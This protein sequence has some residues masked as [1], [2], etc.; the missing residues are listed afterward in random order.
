MDSLKRYLLFEFQDEREEK[1]LSP[2]PREWVIEVDGDEVKIWWPS[3]KNM[4]ENWII[5]AKKVDATFQE[6][7]GRLIFQSSIFFPF[8]GIDMF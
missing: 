7:K 8:K 1:S 4:K 5:Q 3:Q 6:E 2:I